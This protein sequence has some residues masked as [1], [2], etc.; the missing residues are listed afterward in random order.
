MPDFSFKISARLMSHL[1]EALISDE[2]VALLELIKNSY[3]ADA[4]HSIINIDTNF[5]NEYGQGKIEI[6]DD[7]N[8]MSLDVIENS[9]LKLA[10][11]YKIKTQKV[12]PKYNRMSLGNKGVG[13]LSLQRLGSYVNVLTNDGFTESVFNIDWTLFNDNI[14][15]QDIKIPV[16]TNS[17][18]VLEKHGTRMTIYGIKN[19]EL[20]KDKDTFP[21]FKN[22]I[23]SM[24]NPY[25]DGE[26]KFLIEF[27]LDSFRFASDKYDVKLIDK[28][29]DSVV[30]FNFKSESSKLYI[31]IVRKKKYADSRLVDAKK[32]YDEYE[33]DLKELDVSA[34]YMHLTDSFEIDLNNISKSYSKIKN[35][36]LIKSSI[37]GSKETEKRDRNIFLPGDFEGKYFSFDK[38]AGRFSAEDKKFLEN[39]NGVKLFRNNFRILPYGNKNYDWLSLTK[40]SQT[41]SANI[42]KAHSVAGYIY[43]NGEENLL[44]LKEMTNRQGLLEDNYGKNFLTILRDIITKIIVDSDSSFRNDFNANFEQIK[45]AKEGDVVYILGG[46]VSLTKRENHAESIMQHASK[47]ME[48][49]TVSVF[50][51]EEV[52]N[53]KSKIEKLATSISSNADKI[54]MTISSEKK[55]IN[56]EEKLLEKYKI[57]MANSI[58]AESLAHEILKIAIKTKNCAQSIRKEVLKNNIN[59]QVVNA[60]VDMITS[61][62]QFLQRNASVLDSNSYIR[63]NN[64]E[65]VDI[66]CLLENIKDTFP[67]FSSELDNKCS[68]VLTGE[69]FV[70]DI[71]KNNFIV[72]IENLLINSKYWLEKNEIENPTINIDINGRNIIVYDN[73]IGVSK[74]VENNLFDAFVTAKPDLE[75]RGLGLYISSQLINEIEG[76]LTLDDER[77]IYGNK[78]KFVIKL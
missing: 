51:T 1:G 35:N 7:G 72:T 6:L 25:E 16:S 75:G 30:S 23:I 48:Q 4:N 13:R 53:L 44:K 47:L 46:K 68:I 33:F 27:S 69:T 31:N 41:I 49:A 10:T 54:Q 45:N 58:V 77:N 24:L 59:N 19:I 26:S 74:D 67:L 70:A 78:Y 21:R 39:I 38:T 71:I 76:S 63:K 43:I 3:D 28:L 57:V 56:D 8:G 5:S 55:K 34:R 18:P 65:E 62:M 20:W 61:S 17:V 52:T 12:S 60:N 22:E 11:D 14:D 64:F 32:R 50:D 66:K 42:Y 29:A 9:F 15:I 40:Y 2:L 73:G 37:C 36:I